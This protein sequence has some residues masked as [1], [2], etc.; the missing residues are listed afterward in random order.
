MNITNE[1]ALKLLAAAGLEK[2]LLRLTGVSPGTWQ[3]AGVRIFRGT[4]REALRRKEEEALPSAAIRIRIKGDPTF[5][6]AL[7]FNPEETKYISG[8][9]ADDSVYGE[10][11]EDQPEVTIVEI[12]NIVLNALANSVLKAFDRS[13][14]PSVPA[15]FRGDP[16]AIAQWLAAGPAV[17]TVI[18]AAFTMQ[19]GSRSSKAEILAFLPAELADGPLPEK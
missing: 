16:G 19:R 3:L 14:I 10:L 1:N 2:C 6:T 15:Y 9:F 5:I 12:G 8:C 17:F 13:A 11:I 7:L 4:V 18:S